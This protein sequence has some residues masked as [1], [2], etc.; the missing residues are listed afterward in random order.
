MTTKLSVTALGN[1]ETSSKPRMIPLHT[2]ENYATIT[3]VGFLNGKDGA[4]QLLATDIIVANYAGLNGLFNVAINAS[5]KLI[6]LSPVVSS[7]EVVLPVVANNLASFN[8][9]DGSIKDSGIVAAN[10][11]L[12]TTD[13]TDYQ[14]FVSLTDILINS[15]GTWTRTRVAAGDYSLVHTPANDTSVISFDITPQLRAAS[16]RGFK[17]AS[18]DVIC[19]IGVA[20][21][22]AHS[23]TLSSCSYANNVANSVSS[24]PLTGTLPIVTQANPYM[25]NLAITTP[26]FM[27]S[28]ATHYV[29]ELTVDAAG[30]STYSLFGLNLRFT[31]SV[32]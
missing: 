25:T 3:A 2:S 21:L 28:A 29:A 18:I 12:T 17:L 19:L 7:G 11:L 20:A 26:A 30:T 23:M 10:T 1:Y 6:T 27:N 14:N 16:G 4:S 24:V 13:V 9:T 31:K 5:T 22:D 32:A 8:A 15:V